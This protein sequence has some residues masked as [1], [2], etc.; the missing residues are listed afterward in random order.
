MASNNER[1]CALTN[2]DHKSITYNHSVAF[3]ASVMIGTGTLSMPADIAKAAGSDSWLCVILG[4]LCSFLFSLPIV[5]IINHMNEKS[6]TEYLIHLTGKFIG[7]LL[8]LLYSAYCFF[9]VASVFQVFND[10][11]ETYI[12]IETP[13]WFTIALMLALTVYITESEIEITVKTL[14]ILF[15]TLISIIVLIFSTALHMVDFTEMLPFMQS[16]FK[17]I[18]QGTYKTV[19]GYLGFALLLIIAPQLIDKNKGL[20]IFK[21]TF[22][23]VSLTYLYIVI[24]VISTLGLSRT[25]VA[26]WPSMALMMSIS[27]PGRI[28]ERMGIIATMFWVLAT[29]TTV[30]GFYLCG[31]LTFS[32]TFGLKH[33]RTIVLLSAPIVFLISQLPKNTLQIISFISPLNVLGLACEIVIP[34]CLAMAEWIRFRSGK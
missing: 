8:S 31:V 9:S 19:Y 23:I 6:F 32:G 24:I 20:T 3:L 34:A 15:P 27:G 22:F 18:M 13:K 5:Y 12:L 17:E 7:T 14:Y 33:Y 2:N 28:F 16:S 21:K 10:V 30:A 25:K 29:F 11:L 4:S 26:L 1:K